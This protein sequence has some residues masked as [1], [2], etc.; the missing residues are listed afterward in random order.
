MGNDP[1][2]GDIYSA[3][4]TIDPYIEPTPLV[5]SSWLSNELEC[6]VYLKREDTLP[7]G[8][9]KV[10]GGL[11]FAANLA[12]HTHL[13][14]ASTGN[15]GG[16]IAYAGSEFDI[17]VTIVVPE[18][19][20]K[21]KVSAIER[22]GAHVESHGEDMDAACAYAE[23]LSEEPGNRFVHPANEPE[24][25]AG[26]GT[27]GIEIIEQLPEVDLVCCPVGGGSSASGYCLTVGS[28]L[29]AD[30]IGVQT[31][32]ADA[33]YRA[34]HTGSTKSIAEIDTFAEGLA[35]GEAFSLPVRILENRL[36]DFR[37]VNDSDLWNAMGDLLAHESII[38]EGATAAGIAGLRSLDSITG[39]T[40]VIPL[41]GR[42]LS[43]AKLRSV[44]ESIPDS[45]TN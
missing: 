39:K 43:L 13:V 33:T 3:R 2:I 25:I 35:V 30:V 37:R 23:Q 8:A 15:H 27:A 29:D 17:P 36:T 20:N 26:V 38:A 40:V 4:R 45:K 21:R 1:S 14:T 41:S 16:S 10:R 34:W 5:R 6:D 28:V 19:A 22:H 24:L 11:N 12:D 9:F 32:G 18:G 42:N 7:T 31:A 44:V